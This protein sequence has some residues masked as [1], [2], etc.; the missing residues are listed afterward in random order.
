MS[1]E[2]EFERLQRTRF[3]ARVE[4]D[5]ARLR[6]AAPRLGADPRAMGE[7]ETVAHGLAGAGGTFGF[8]PISE[9]AEQVEQL[10]ESGDAAALRPALAALDAT[11][12]AALRAGP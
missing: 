12:V 7:I 1:T 5:L 4:G 11:L 6:A 3:L 8:M 2:A 9:Q 10:A